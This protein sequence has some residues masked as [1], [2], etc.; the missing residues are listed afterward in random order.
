MSRN[1]LAS[2]RLSSPS[3]RVVD[4]SHAQLQLLPEQLLDHLPQLRHL[5]LSNNPLPQLPERLSG[6]GEYYWTRR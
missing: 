6:Q 2:L 4:A 5:N 1:P 3:L